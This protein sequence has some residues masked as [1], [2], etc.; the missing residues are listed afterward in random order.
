M[1]INSHTIKKINMFELTYRSV[2]LNKIN[3]VEITKI[4][5]ISREFNLKNNITG[6]LLFY[7]NEFV[8]ILEGEQDV[9]EKL[10]A[11]IEKDKRHSNVTL[12]AKKVKNE[13]TFKN[14]AMAYHEITNDDISEISKMLFVNNFI[15]LCEIAEKP[16]NAIMLFWFISKQILKKDYKFKS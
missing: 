5:N 16:T 3:S 15:A 11:K 9:I 4:L 2:A 7:K 1:K 10:Y 12:I 14:W 13:R 8:Q 6:C